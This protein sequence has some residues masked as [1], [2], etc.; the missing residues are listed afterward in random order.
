MPRG[1][2]RPL[3]GLLGD[4]DGLRILGQ[5]KIIPGD[6]SKNTLMQRVKGEVQ[7]RMPLNRLAVSGEE[8]ALIETWMREG[9]ANN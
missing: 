8:I 5:G 4:P 9:A 3:R 2:D 1:P 6:P 7:P